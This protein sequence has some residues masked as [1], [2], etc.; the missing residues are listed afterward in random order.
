MSP[1]AESIDHSTALFRALADPTRLRVLNLLRDGERCVCELVDVIGG[2]Q[3]KISRHLAH[4]REAGLV[5]SRRRGQWIYYRLADPATE[6]HRR[7]IAC[8]GE[9]FG[10]VAQLKAD[11]QRLSKAC[12]TVENDRCGSGKECC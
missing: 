10:D 7:L 5:V 4:L 3:P 2:P 12:R 1:V 9:C 8:V 11:R 6:L